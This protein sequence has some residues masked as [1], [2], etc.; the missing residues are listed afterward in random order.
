MS[1]CDD[2]FAQAQNAARAGNLAEAEGLLQNYLDEVPDN[3]EARCLRG[4]ILAKLGKLPEAEE[5]FTALAAGSQDI[6][7]LNNLAVIYGRQN[8]LQDALGTLTDAIDAD[9]TVAELYYNIGAV[10]ERLEH[11]K[12]ASMAYAKVAELNDRYIPAYNKLGIT[13]FK[14]GLFPKALETFALILKDHPGNQAILNNMGVILAVQGKTG[15]AIQNYRQALEA[16]PHYTKAKA[17]LELAGKPQDGTEPAFLLD[18]E[19]EFLFIE[20]LTAEADETSETLP[21]EESP[22]ETGLSI[23]SKT[24]LELIRYL[25]RMTEGLPPKAKE[26]FLRSDARL[27]ME[28]LIAVLEGHPGIL[29]EIREWKLASESGENK[30]PKAVPGTKVPDLPGTLDYL[31]KMAGALADSDLSTTLRHKVDTVILELNET[32][33]GPSA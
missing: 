20:N 28:Y 19:P 2:V 29:Q 27:S 13:Q 14:L 31:R 32:T 10:Y 16:D 11:Y 25:K 26:F 24:A 33:G 1:S 17:N 3:R 15:E 30:A 22:K 9:P 18:E 4:T 6:T 5:D 12:A 8:K 7:T 23:S 21:P